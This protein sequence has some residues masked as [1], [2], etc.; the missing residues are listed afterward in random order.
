MSNHSELPLTVNGQPTSNL[1]N[2]STKRTVPPSARKE[3]G[4]SAQI[5]LV[6][7]I[8]SFLVGRCVNLFSELEE[9]PDPTSS[10][11]KVHPF[12][13]PPPPPPAAHIHT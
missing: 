10:S 13:P 4:Y 8:A 7:C 9:L 11:P 2:T 12:P 5:V 3:R 6:L 1:P